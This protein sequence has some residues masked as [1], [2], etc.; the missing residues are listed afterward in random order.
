M[1]LLL[2]ALSLQA[3]FVLRIAV[4]ALVEPTSTALQRSQAWRLAQRAGT[5]RPP[6]WHHEPVALESIAPAL[7]RAVIASEDSGF[8]RHRGVEWRALESAWRRHLHAERTTPTVQGGRHARQGMPPR[9]IGG[10]TLTQQLA[11]NLFLS[12]ERTLPRKAQELVL[13]LALEAMLD[14]RRLLALYLN[15]VEWGEGVFG[16]QAAA[17]RH[18]GVDAG[19]L[20]VAQSARLAAMLPAPRRF[21][22]EPGSPRLA[23]RS[24]TIRTQMPLVQVP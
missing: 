15:H 5:L 4:L 24:A 10:S 23:A 22:S 2:M 11:K 17:R 12:G 14:K 3:A 19:A 21:E 1:L 16:A 9:V 8:V 6:R 20:D 13:A 7:P 18:F